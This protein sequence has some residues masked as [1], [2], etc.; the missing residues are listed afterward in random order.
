M[1][2]AFDCNGQDALMLRARASLPARADLAFIGHKAVQNIDL[3]IINCK[4]L[5]RTK[6]TELRAC[7]ESTFLTLFH[8]GIYL[9][10]H[11][12]LNSNLFLVHP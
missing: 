2:G 1:A 7:V 6:L 5:I 12:N 8:V 3:F 9:L 10:F 11:K 4:T